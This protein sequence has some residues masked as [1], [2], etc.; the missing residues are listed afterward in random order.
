M[1]GELVP[2]RRC[3]DCGE[4]FQPHVVNCSEC[5]TLLE[6]GI[7]GET[8]AADAE[9]EEDAAAYV[10]LGSTLDAETARMAA[11]HLAA[12]RL[13]F[14]LAPCRTASGRRLSGLS[15]FV[16]EADAVAAGGLLVR[17][18]ILPPIDDSPPVA[19]D[20]GP[21]PACQTHVAPGTLECPECGLVLGGEID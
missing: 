6:D 14:R 15:L 16:N 5:G 2:V 3:P 20:G 18:G 9:P 17:E 19:L 11:E 13:R 12:A 10:S 21:C 7:E 4:E 1:S 8:P